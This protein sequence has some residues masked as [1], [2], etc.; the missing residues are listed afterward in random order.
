MEDV[1][2]NLT[3][4]AA[5]AILNATELH[6]ECWTSHIN[7]ASGLDLWI[8]AIL[9]HHVYTNISIMMHEIGQHLF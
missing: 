9:D 3:S 6:T 4:P 5:L 1:N 7:I 2:G 8:T